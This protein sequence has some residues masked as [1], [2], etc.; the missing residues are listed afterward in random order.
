MLT[1]KRSKFS[2]PRGVTYLN[3]AYMAPL[4]AAVEKVGIRG[5]RSKRNP[6]SITAADFFGTTE[7]LRYEFAKTINVPEPRR[8]VVIPSVSYGMAT[9]AK[10]VTIS[11]E[12]NIVVAAEQFP[13]NYY[14]WQRLCDENKATLRVVSPPSVLQ[15]RGKGWNEKILDSID[16]QTRI[17]ALGHVHWADGT[18]FNLMDIRRKTREM[19]ALLIIDG[20]Q[21]VGALPFDVGLIDPDALIVAGY[22]WLMGPYS[23]GLAYF[24]KYFDNGIPLEENWINRMNSENFSAL[25]NYK[26]AY[27]DGLLRFEVGEHSNFIHVPMMLRAVTQLNRWGISNIQEYCRAISASCIQRLRENGYWIEE[28]EYRGSHLF[29][30]RIPSDRNIEDLKSNLSKRK[31]FVSFRGDAIRVSPNVYNTADDLD[32]LAKALTS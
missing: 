13:S 9:V 19:G 10:N 25:V 20:T 30:I 23:I 7:A 32:R 29:G 3:C 1:S 15:D 11:G 28:E 18:K 17:V 12:N 2:L 6:A 24:G 14:S 22:K 27:Q 4:P 8:I 5:L 31:I 26:E 21:S 16:S